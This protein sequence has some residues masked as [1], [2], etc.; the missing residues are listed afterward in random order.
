MKLAY[1]A[2]DKAGRQ[3]TSTVEAADTAAA[4]ET[5]RRQG[6]YVTRIAPEDAAGP[7]TR[8]ALRKSKT[9]RVKDLAMLMRQLHA[10][11]SCGTPLVEAL[12]AMEQQSRPGPWRDALAGVRSRV[13]QGATFAAAAEEYPDYFDCVCLSLLGAGESSGNL[14]AMLDRI[15]SMTRKQLAIR[16]AIAGAMIYPC[17]LTV[18]AV[19][20]LTVLLVFVVPRFG[21]LF[22]SL[23]A[24]LPPT[25][26]ALL[27]ISGVLRERWWVVLPA[28][29]AAAV[30]LKVW[31]SRPAGRRTVDT[32]VLGLPQ[33]GRIVRNFATA[34]I[35]RLLGVL[36]DGHVDVLEAL[37]LTARS[38]SNHRYAEL[39][40]DAE[41]AVTQGRTLHSAFSR[42]DLVSPAVCEAIRNGEQSGRVGMLLLNMAD[43]LD[44][45]NEI[46]VKSLT[47]IMEPVILVLM[48]IVVGAV[49]VSMFLPLFDLTAMAQQGGGG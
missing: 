14:P 18:I 45:E 8:R 33:V 2:F 34:R 38:V 6:L 7:M 17:L 12:M 30:S 24:K 46:V 26:E 32:V 15:A 5:L 10:L 4:S 42:S 29:A 35:L 36:L 25:T 19:N 27:Y 44:E 31:L 41:D 47:S 28:L 43:F 37:R 22:S 11:V 48:G 1:V 13:E 39:L 40:H 20:V 21:E 3:V 23:G 16:N 49:A 9:R